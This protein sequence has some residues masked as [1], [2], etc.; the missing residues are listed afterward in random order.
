MTTAS[1]PLWCPSVIVITVVVVIVFRVVGAIIARV[2]ATRRG[3]LSV[4]AVGRVVLRLLAS[5][6]PLAP[7]HPRLFEQSTLFCEP[8]SLLPVLHLVLSDQSLR[9]TAKDI[10]VFTEFANPG[11]AGRV[12]EVGVLLLSPALAGSVS[13]E[14]RS[15]ASWL[16][17]GRRLLRGLAALGRRGTSICWGMHTIHAGACLGTLGRDSRVIWSN[18]RAS[19]RR[20]GM[21][22]RRS[23]RGGIGAR[24]LRVRPVFLAR[25][26]HLVCR[27]RA[28]SEG[29]LRLSCAILCS[30]L[31]QQTD[32]LVARGRWGCL[33][34]GN[35]C[36]DDTALFRRT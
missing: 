24:G 13:I 18:G 30:L 11:L 21:G 29:E 25:P 2:V 26:N 9:R 1:A 34:V 33:C 16:A 12:V 19:A 35:G 17:R 31:M 32:V 4:L 15:T 5:L 14:L 27:V 28:A 20:L 23:G 36:G 8:T 6:L 10:F 7:L 3:I 22:R